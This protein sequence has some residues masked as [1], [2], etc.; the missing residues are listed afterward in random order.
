MPVPRVIPLVLF[1]LG[2]GSSTV[3]AAVGPGLAEVSAVMASEVTPAEGV[4]AMNPVC[5]ERVD[6]RCDATDS[7]CD[8][9]IDE[10]C[11]GVSSARLEVAV[12]WTGAADLEL[13]LDGPDAERARVGDVACDDSERRLRA[14]LDAV[15][16]G[17][18]ALSLR[19]ADDCGGEG[20]V[21][22]SVSASLDG[23][24]VGTFNLRISPGTLAPV[25][26][27]EVDEASR[28]AR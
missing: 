10:G 25:V 12:A 17:R 1:S 14:E 26:S 18:Y 6:E 9:R 22:A 20:D 11:E 27:F 2:C 21:T 13:V 4:A 19:H 28:A 3:G 7:D 24:A 15:P 16:S 5:A 23:A 8:G